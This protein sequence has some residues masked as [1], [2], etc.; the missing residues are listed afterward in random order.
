MHA[1]VFVYQHDSGFERA[2]KVI[3]DAFVAFNNRA[4]NNIKEY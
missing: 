2:A 4:P 3:R 1:L